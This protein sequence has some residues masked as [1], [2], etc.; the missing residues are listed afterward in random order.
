MNEWKPVLELAKKSLITFL[1]VLVLAGMLV[2]VA[3]T[4]EENAN[5]LLAQTQSE[6]QANQTQLESKV[7]DLENM[8]SHIKRYETLKAQGLI[9]EPMRSKWVED[10]KESHIELRLPDA[11]TVELQTSKPLEMQSTDAVEGDALNLQ[12]WMH[13][14]VFDI[15]GVHEQ[16]LLEL[17]QN[18]QNRV[19]GRFRLQECLLTEPKETGLNARCVLRFVSIPIQ[20]N[21]GPSTID[22]AP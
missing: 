21:N 12:P 3:K 1:V 11:L 20:E 4:Y 10:F 22:A 5:T 16:E 8:E 13:E 14:L 9:G 6:L 15:S 7:A 2:W 19:K 18:Y 17:M